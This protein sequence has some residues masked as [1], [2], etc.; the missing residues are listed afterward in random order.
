MYYEFE[1][2][3]HNDN[4][5]SMTFRSLSN[6][7]NRRFLTRRLSLNRL[8]Y[9]IFRTKKGGPAFLN[10]LLYLLLN[11]FKQFTIR[12][13]RISFIR[14]TLLFNRFNYTLHVSKGH[15]RRGRNRN[16]WGLLRGYVFWIGRWILIIVRISNA[17]C[18]QRKSFVKLPYTRLSLQYIVINRIRRRRRMA[19]INMYQKDMFLPSLSTMSFFVLMFLRPLRIIIH[20]TCISRFITLRRFN[21]VIR[22]NFLIMTI[23]FSS[24]LPFG[25]SK[26]ILQ[27]LYWI[28]LR[29]ISRS[30]SNVV[31]GSITSMIRSLRTMNNLM[32]FRGLRSRLTNLILPAK[33]VTI[34]SIILNRFTRSRDRI[35]CLLIKVRHRRRILR[36]NFLTFTAYRQRKRLRTTYR[37]LPIRATMMRRVKLSSG[38]SYTMKGRPIMRVRAIRYRANVN[39]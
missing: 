3:R 31:N 24:I 18:L 39:L 26:A 29:S 13:L 19:F 22:V 8:S 33:H 34:R 1:A 25:K 38:A 27:G 14:F 21:R 23:M 7:I 11:Q 36:R 15:D 17:R 16:W 9:R 20:R 32:I 28:T 5:R 37:R 12:R 6:L 30:S 10:R 35:A 4:I 2:K